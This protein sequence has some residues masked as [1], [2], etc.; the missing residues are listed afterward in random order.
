MF[1]V[2]LWKIICPIGFHQGFDH[3]KSCKPQVAAGGIEDGGDDGASGSGGGGCSSDGGGGGSGGC[4]GGNLGG[5]G[6]L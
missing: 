6:N 2:Y 3:V 4:G 1:V 5:L